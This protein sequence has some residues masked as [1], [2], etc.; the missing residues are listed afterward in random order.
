LRRE[1]TGYVLDEK[2]AGSKSPGD[3]GEL[4]EESRSLSRESCSSSGDGEVLAGEAP[5]EEMNTFGTL[6]PRSPLL[7]PCNVGCVSEPS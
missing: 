4:E 5:C 7:P 6:K 1:E 3:S 2:E